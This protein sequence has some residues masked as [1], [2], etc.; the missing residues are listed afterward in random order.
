MS[1]NSS[2]Y[3][4]RNVYSYHEASLE[5]ALRLSAHLLQYYRERMILAGSSTGQVEPITLT[6]QENEVVYNQALYDKMMKEN[7]SNN[8]YKSMKRL[9][10]WVCFGNDMLS[11]LIIVNVLRNL[12]YCGENC[13]SYL[14]ALKELL[15]L[16][17][18]FAD[19]RRDLIF[20][21]PTVLDDVDY[22]NQTKFGFQINKSIER[23][24]FT[25]LTS[26]KITA[27]VNSFL[28]SIVECVDKNESTAF[29]MITFLL[30][31]VNSDQVLFKRLM[32]Y[33]SPNHLHETFYDWIFSFVK[34]YLDQ[35]KNAYSGYS[36]YRQSKL[37]NSIMKESLI[38]F[39]ENIHK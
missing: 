21:V 10:S 15:A 24:S 6:H 30:Q 25:F 32:H 28:R 35:E 14:E 19:S 39:E 16:R 22:Y 37:F 3:E 23:P 20:G 18:E 5:Y 33:P 13:I 36:M 12:G 7:Y 31:I 8:C 4:S 26:L 34:V 1:K 29:I 27:N 17:D 38:I 2:A 11:T 9:L